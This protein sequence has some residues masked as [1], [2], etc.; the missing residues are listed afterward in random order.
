MSPIK[1]RHFLQFAG[2]TLAAVGLSQFDLIRQANRYGRVLAQ[3]SPGRKLAL[4]VGINAYPGEIDWLRGC[5]TDVELQRELLV[6][7]YGFNP[8]DVMIVSDDVSLKPTRQNILDAFEQHLIQQAQPGDVVVFHFSG[9]GS[10]VLDPTALFTQAGRGVN[11]TMVPFDRAS[12]QPDEVQDIMGRSLFLL[13]SAL[14]TDDVTAVLDCCHSGGGTRGNLVVRAVPSRVGEDLA[15]PS[16]TEL[17]F[18]QRWMK[19]LGLSE[20]QLEAMR[21]KGIAKGVAI[22]SA[23]YNQ[24]AADAPFDGFYA[25]AFTYLLTRYLWQ[26]SVNQSLGT[27]FV[28]LARSTKDV[29]NS[30]GVAQDPIFA[31]NP[32]GNQQQP[33]YF[34]NPA[35]P[36]SE[37]VVRSVNPQTGEIEFWLGG[38]SSRSLAS[39]NKGAV[40]SAIAPSGEELG[41][42]EQERREGLVGYGKVRPEKPFTVKPGMFLR[43][44]VRGVPTNLTLRLGLDASLGQDQAAA[45]QALRQINRVEVVPMG[46]NLDCLLGRMTQSYRS[47]VERQALPPINSIGLFTPALAPIE[48]TFGEAGE[49]VSRAVERLQPRLKSLLAGRLLQEMSGEGKT[50]R[51]N[52]RTAIAPT[53]KTLA[54]SSKL[55]FKPGTELQVRVTNNEEESLYIAIVTIGS[56]GTLQVRYPYW[57]APEDAAIVAPGQEVSVPKSNEVPFRTVGPAGFFE[58]LVIA[59]PT[60]IRDA[61]KALQQIGRGRELTSRSPVTLRGD[62]PVEVMGALLADV[63][64]ATRADFEDAPASVRAVDTKRLAIISNMIEVVD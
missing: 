14:K 57:D 40:F 55:Q 11:G 1:R 4:L 27:V 52:V 30:S 64:Q 58:V 49:S 6:H 13:M 63:D 8:Q 31:A 48:G 12:T 39:V 26:Q 3:G 19:R 45:T 7:R 41:E 22:G 24:F 23:Q 47:V 54:V 34:L 56:S 29:S 60:P 61:L 5:L 51:L 15:T 17:E 59:S 2:S 18:Q 42:I 21:R 53:Q 43:E 16:Q 62:E 10:L 25:G 35:T 50:S 36:F 32:E 28:N 44:R 20:S 46:E 33:V 38:V 37:A 9:H